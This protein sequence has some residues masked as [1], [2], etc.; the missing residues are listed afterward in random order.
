MPRAKRALDET[1][2]N[3]R[4]PAKRSSTEKASNAAAAAKP[5]KS[6][7]SMA[8]KVAEKPAKQTNSTVKPAKNQTTTA[9][10][11]KT[12][13]EKAASNGKATE[14][15]PL[16]SQTLTGRSTDT[17]VEESAG[18]GEPVQNANV[19]DMDPDPGAASLEKKP[20]GEYICIDRPFFDFAAEK[21]D[22]GDDE[23]DEEIWEAYIK[24]RDGP[25]RMWAKPAV[26]H[27][28]WKWVIMVGAWTEYCELRVKQDYVVP[29]NFDIVH[30]FNDFHG[31]GINSMIED[32]V[33]G[34]GYRKGSLR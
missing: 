27:P 22:D 3:A 19:Q 25:D 5:A 6:Q 13:P 30:I 23:E 31:C 24:E 21:E 16:E 11:A 28:D 2:A 33:S 34:P 18:N 10:S 29:E 1:D 8:K 9:K 17:A 26:E 12:A 15:Q 14:Q 4:P 7:T 32:M 20:P